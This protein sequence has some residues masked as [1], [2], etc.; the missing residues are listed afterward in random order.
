MTV[1]SP[2][3]SPRFSPAVLLVGMVELNGAMKKVNPS[4]DGSL[5]GLMI[6]EK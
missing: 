5:R 6:K 4:T 3:N 2:L 1:V